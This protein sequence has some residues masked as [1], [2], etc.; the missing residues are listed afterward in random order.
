MFIRIFISLFEKYLSK[1]TETEKIPYDFL[2]LGAADHGFNKGNKELIKDNI[3]VPKNHVIMGTH[4]IYYSHYGAKTIF[5]YRLKYPVYFDKNFKELFTFFK[6]PL[7]TG[8]CYP[9][10]FT[11]ENSTSQI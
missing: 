1:N 8:V 6:D 3:Y 11:V 5:D 2:M 4:A 7:R 9:N 10:L